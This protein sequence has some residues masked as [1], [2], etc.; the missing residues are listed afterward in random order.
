MDPRQTI[1]DLRQQRFGDAE[2]LFLAGSVM[3]G[4][5]TPHSDLDV[6][7]VYKSLPAAYRESLYHQGWSV[8]LFVH[9][10]ETLAYFCAQDRQRGVPSLPAMLA[11]GL[12]VPQ[13]TS[14]SRRLKSEAI[15]LLKNGP[16][17]WGQPDIDQARYAL[18]DICDDLRQPRNHAERVAS[19][20]RLY[21][22]V[23]EFF[24]RTQHQWSATGKSIPGRLAQANPERADQFAQAFQQL[25]E[26]QDAG[27]VLQLC[28]EIVQPYGG[29]LFAQPPLVAPSDWR[30]RP[31][32]R[33]FSQ[34]L[35]LRPGEESDIPAILN[36][37]ERNRE[38]LAPL[39]P[40]RPPDFFTPQY[41]R[42]YLATAR[43]ELTAEKAV[44]LFVFPR[45]SDEVIGV[46]HFSQLHRGP[47]QA[48]YVGYS[49]DG[50]REGQG[51]MREALAKAIEY[52][53][54]TL[55]FH[56]IMANYLPENERSARLLQRLGFQIEGRAPKY[57]RIGGEWRD[58]VLTAL[59]RC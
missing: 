22:A 39:E 15:A 37:F 9:D 54:H 30:H 14:F 17:A 55:G 4:Q 3:R 48:G 29:F 2:V 32:P 8:E 16:P 13:S 34:R 40:D 7:V 24:L 10:P 20:C 59:T 35:L 47:F 56:R 19:G 53:F 42:G 36:Y 31:V 51:L 1:E 46:I 23:A 18:S 25:F 38:R 11:E 21:P 26:N 57:L 44:R 33:L 49:L 6:V 5:G 43:Q 12:E 27:A 50:A 58:H 28:Q 52:V 41:W 45:Q